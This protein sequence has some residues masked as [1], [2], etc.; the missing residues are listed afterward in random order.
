MLHV[1]RLPRQAIVPLAD[2]DTDST[3][4]LFRQYV[5]DTNAW[6]SDCVSRVQNSYNSQSMVGAVLSANYTIG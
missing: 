2:D 4:K 3:T 1:R 6:S 5:W